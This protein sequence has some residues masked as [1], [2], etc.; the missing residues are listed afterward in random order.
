MFTFP[1]QSRRF[2]PSQDDCDHDSEF[3]AEMR[4]EGGDTVL[5]LKKGNQATRHGRGCRKNW[6][7]HVDSS[8]LEQMWL[9]ITDLDQNQHKGHPGVMESLKERSEETARGHK[10]EACSVYLQI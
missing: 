2:V 4:D 5:Q 3:K 10:K 7:S 9:K 8:E 1:R 6:L